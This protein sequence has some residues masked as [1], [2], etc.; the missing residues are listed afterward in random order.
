MDVLAVVVAG[1]AEDLPAGLES[2]TRIFAGDELDACD[3]GKWRDVTR[4]L[5]TLEDPLEAL[6]S[7]PGEALDFLS[8][9]SFRAA[10]YEGETGHE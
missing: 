10:D 7:E 5:T 2:W 8:R 4:S 9:R 3:G 6:D 1:R